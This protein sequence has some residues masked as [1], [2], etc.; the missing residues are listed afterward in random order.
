MAEN[1]V[2]LYS[3]I[4][5]SPADYW[6]YA[7]YAKKDRREN[8]IQNSWDNF[9]EKAK[10]AEESAMNILNRENEGFNLK[11]TETFLNSFALTSKKI[12]FNSSKK[13]LH[14]L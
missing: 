14:L 9:A 8:I 11:N 1:L 4:G 7:Y 3:P 2:Q 13:N 6:K 10:I 12:F 5:D